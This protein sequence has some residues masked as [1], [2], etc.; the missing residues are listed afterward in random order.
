MKAMV[1]CLLFFSAITLA[2]QISLQEHQ[3]WWPD[4]L[5]N[6]LWC[7][8]TVRDEAGNFIR[9]L[10]AEDFQIVER[11]YDRNDNLLAQK[12]ISPPFESSSYTFNGPGFWEKSVNSDKL[13]IAFFIDG[14]GS[15][16]PHIENI[17]RQ[18]HLFLDRLIET[19]TDFRMFIGL[20]ETEDQPEW[21]IPTYPERFF[22]PMMAQEIAAA[23]DEIDTWGEW[24]NLTWG[25]DVLL[26]SLNLDWR[27]DARKI[28]VIVT[29]VY[30]DSVYGPNWYFSSGCVSS[31]SAADMMLREKNIYL[32]YCQPPEDQMSK[33]E[34]GECYSPKVNIKVRENNFDA[35]EKINPKV[36]RLDWPFDQSQIELER[37]PLVD[38]KY[39]LSWVSDWRDHSSTDRIEVQIRLKNAS[40][41]TS[42]VF[43]PFS[44]PQGQSVQTWVRNIKFFIFDES[45]RA[46]EGRGNVTMQL[47]RTM[48]QLDRVSV[49]M[50]DASDENG[51]I[52]FGTKRA[53]RYYY[54]IKSAG[55]SRYSYYQL[56]QRSSG[57][58]DVTAQGASPT[59]LIVETYAKD[60]ELY[61]ARGL[62]EEMKKL[63]ISNSEI[64]RTCLLAQN[65]LGQIQRDGITLGEM[66]ALKR[67]NVTLGTFINC[68]AYADVVQRSAT[69]DMVF[70]LQKATSMVRKAR[71]V[72]GALHS[73]KHIFM[74]VMNTLIDIISVN[75]SGIA[76]RASIEQLIDRL[77]NY[78]K[79]ELIDDIM[80]TVESKLLEVLNNPEGI[81][82]Y[83]SNFVREWVREQLEPAQVMNLA[84]EFVG[85]SLVSPRFTSILES[86][87]KSLLAKSSNKADEWAGKYWNYYEKSM[88][89]KEDF[90]RMRKD[91]MDDLFDV[92][93]TAL[94]DKP[95][96]D[97]WEGALTVFRETIPLIVEFIRLV[98]ARYPELSEV[99]RAL[100][101]LYKVLDTIGTLTKTYEMALKV[102]HLDTLRVRL[103]RVMDYTF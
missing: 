52:D 65:W 93:R 18:L 22:G 84:M 50:A 29:D 69:Q 86:Q 54:V 72:V 26:W 3:V 21:P 88:K 24:W 89:M 61:R 46:F 36:K 9:G 40:A 78:V 55:M 79:D 91:L 27:E 2:T 100:E 67:F 8:V 51:V 103:E 7:S 56:A 10:K 97:D 76:A 101:S 96:I 85:D 77:V 68:A 64:L 37:V 34:L 1:I 90:E 58:V 45:R 43:Y 81:V 5:W 33:I 99:R 48:G 42:F 32:Y 70:I 41:S 95:N 44:D 75:W 73:A 59:Q 53:G 94:T 20:Y 15:M 4:N 98:E 28:V 83:F 71:E 19:A 74:T 82:D 39:Y 14:T 92:S 60:T 23:I 35:L 16:E 31:M 12:V 17:K 102:N 66:E 47:Y 63:E 87:L 80:K 57:F 25:Y 13:D 62:L 6:A 38:S 30:T 49:R 11:A